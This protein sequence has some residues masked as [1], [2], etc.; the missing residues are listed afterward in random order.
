[1]KN[2]TITTHIVI[3]MMPR[4]SDED[5]DIMERDDSKDG[6]YASPMSD[7]WLPWSP[8]DIDDIRKIIDNH[9]DPKQQFIFEAFLDGLTYNDIS[10]TGKYWRYHFQKGL[11]KI[12]KELSV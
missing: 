3:A 9:L 6:H 12:K 1:M 11:E 7:G 2:T 4:L 5:P 8:E 10:V